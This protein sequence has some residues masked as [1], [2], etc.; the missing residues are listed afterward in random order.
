MPPLPSNLE[1]IDTTAQS[2]CGQPVWVT[3]PADPGR[4]KVSRWFCRRHDCR[5]CARWKAK[6]NGWAV[7]EFV[8]TRPCHHVTLTIRRNGAPL[9][10][11]IN[12]LLAG[13]KKLQRRPQWRRHVL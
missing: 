11:L 7:V 6:T 3:D 8:G 9:R 5:D 13:F 2:A 4:W 1:L 12:R 10:T